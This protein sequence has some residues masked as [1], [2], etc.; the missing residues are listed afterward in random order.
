[1]TPRRRFGSVPDDA[2]SSTTGNTIELQLKAPTDGSSQIARDVDASNQDPLGLKVI[3]R[4][5]SERQVD[6]VFVHGLGGSSRLTWSKNRDLHYFWPLKFLPLEPVIKDARILTFGYNSNFRPGSG[7]N[8]LS[9]LDFAKDLLFDL[10]Y[11]QDESLAEPEDLGM[12][13][14]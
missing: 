3:H 14:V 9:I 12:G 10:K 11:S 7:K 6:I 4:P 1:L 5:P 8:K 13:Q 2:T